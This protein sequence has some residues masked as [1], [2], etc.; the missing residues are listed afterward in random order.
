M[1]RGTSWDCRIEAE[2][3]RLVGEFVGDFIVE[4]ETACKLE[5]GD[6]A[7]VI[8]PL[9]N[10]FDTKVVAEKIGVIACFKPGTEA[11]S[12]DNVGPWFDGWVN[13]DTMEAVF[14]NN[15]IA[16]CHIV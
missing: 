4:I 9:V 8:V 10:E 14:D 11:I 13:V 3:I 12:A 5:W 15:A 6:R 16:C 7:H 2:D 1:C